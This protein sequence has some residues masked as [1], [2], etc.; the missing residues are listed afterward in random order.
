MR[1]LKGKNVLVTG[2]TSGIGQAMAVR[3]AEYGANVAV[4]YLRQEEEA[5]DTEEQVHA[6]IRRVKEEGVREVLVRGDVSRED[7]VVAMVEDTVRQL[8]S[9]DILVNNAGIQISRALPRAVG[10]RLR[11]GARRQPA[12]LV[13]VRPR[14]DPALRRPGHP[15]CGAEH[16]QRPPAHPQARLPGL[17]GQQGRHGQPDHHVALEY[18]GRGIRVNAIGPGATVTPIN[19]AWVDDPAK[20][21]QVTAHIPMPRPGTSDEMAGVACF[22]ASEGRLHHRA[23]HLRRRRTDALRRLPRTLVLGM[24]AADQPGPWWPSPFGADD[25]HGMLNLVTDAKRR[26]ALAR[27]APR[28]HVRPRP[29]HRRACAGVR[30]SPP[31]AGHHRAPHQRQTRADPGAGHGAGGSSGTTR[32]TG[33]SSFSRPPS[34]APT[35]MLN[36]LQIGDRGYN[37]WTVSELAEPWAPTGSAPDAPSGRDP[38]LARRRPGRR[39]VSALERGDVV[40]VDDVKD[41][42]DA[43]RW[44]PATPCC[45]TRWGRHWTH[46]D[47]YRTPARLDLARWLV[48][49]RVPLTGCDTWSYGPVPAEDP[50]R[51]F[52]SGRAPAGTGP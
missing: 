11:Q 8:G 20:A 13:P 16:Q 5:S 39:G 38:R 9:V 15:R 12:R 6:C 47:R 44:S 33:S 28:P 27:G 32:S 17:L 26:D 40:T 45:S 1:G 35:D 34:S 19:R 41:A 21:E 46:P 23:D 31:D 49:Q 29:G 4:N 50:A 2:G 3:F 52:V 18:A 51:P 7:D 42:L 24:S 37:G 22:L 10:C 30:G 25:Q 48:E 14:G 36:H 43:G